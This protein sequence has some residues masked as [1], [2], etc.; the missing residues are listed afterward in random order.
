MATSLTK[1][2]KNS[3]CGCTET[4]QCANHYKQ[5]LAKLTNMPRVLKA[6]I[7]NLKTGIG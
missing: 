4:E 5:D 6:G 7:G 1:T 3:I 2:K